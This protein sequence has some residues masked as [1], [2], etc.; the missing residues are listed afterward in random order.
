MQAQITFFAS[1]VIWFTIPDYFPLRVHVKESV[2]IF[3]GPHLFLLFACRK[4]V[5]WF[6]YRS[7]KLVACLMSVVTFRPYETEL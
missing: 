4:D 2:G 5:K 1:I 7:L 3:E 6:L